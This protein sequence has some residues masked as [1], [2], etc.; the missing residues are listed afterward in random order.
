MYKACPYA[1]PDSTSSVSYTHL[2]VYKRQRFDILLDGKYASWVKFANSLRLR[3]A[4]RIASVAPDKACAE[5]QKIKENDYGFFEAETGGAIVSTKSGDTNPLGEL[6]RVWNE[7]YMSANM[8]SILVGYDDPRLG[9]YFEHLSL[10][11]I[12]T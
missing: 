11:H 4:M 1:E 3:L 6:N 8:E 7:T 2:D 9:A 5:I 10:I 12:C